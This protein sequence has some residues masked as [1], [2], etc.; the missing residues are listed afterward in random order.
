MRTD[1][2]NFYTE[3]EARNPMLSFATAV[4]MPVATFKE[5]LLA[6]FSAGAVHQ[7]AVSRQLALAARLEAQADAELAS[8]FD[9]HFAAIFGPQAAE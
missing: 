2:S 1:F 7:A 3:L 9:A 5:L 6:A 4:G 8:D